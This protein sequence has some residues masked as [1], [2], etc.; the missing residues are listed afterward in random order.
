MVSHTPFFNLPA[1]IV[2]VLLLLKSLKNVVL[3]SNTV[4]SGLI[5]SLSKII[6][7][8]HSTFSLIIQSILYSL[9][10][11]IEQLALYLLSSKLIGI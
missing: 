9:E 11:I 10:F 1:V 4:S 7:L 8:G 3:G 2:I 5:I 6:F